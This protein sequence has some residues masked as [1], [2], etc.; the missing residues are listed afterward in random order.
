M[1]T[2]TTASKDTRYYIHSIIALCIMIFGRFVP[3]PYPLTPEGMLVLG[4]LVGAVYSYVNQNFFWGS[5]FGLLIIGTS[6]ITTVGAVF[7]SMMSNGTFMF[8]TALFLFVGYLNSVGFAR[9][10][11]LKFVQA[12]VTKGRPWVLTLFLMIAAFLPASVMSVTAVFVMMLPILYAIC[13]EVG[14]QPTEKWPVL[15]A[16]GIASS[17]GLALG[18]WPF[19]VGPVV[20]FGQMAAT[21]YEGGIPFAQY[22]AFMTVVIGLCLLS[23]VGV[24]KFLK[25]DV[26]KLYAY[27]PP[28]EKVEFTSDQKFSLFLVGLLLAWFILPQFIPAGTPLRIFFAQFGPF[29]IASTIVAFGTFVR[30]DG[31]SRIDM[32]EATKGLQLWPMIIMVGSVLVMADILTRPEHGFVDFVSVNLAP[33]FGT[34]NALFFTIAIMFFALILT[35]FVQGSLVFTIMIPIVVPI[36]MALGFPVMASIAPFAVVANMGIPLPSSHPL[37]AVLHGHEFVG[38]KMTLK[39]IW[40]FMGVFFLIALVIGVPLGMLIF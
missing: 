22:V 1:S 36:A 18:F 40:I 14:I 19:Q 8:L 25:P 29:A 17:C 34:G 23:I 38:P 12:K 32:L 3:A 35:S 33:I 9:I 24:I 5:I 37:G 27:S 10:V 11:A 7:S 39:Y 2:A 31:K 6:E 30:K 21:G 13:E 26:S 15:T 16:I 28:E 20:M 4:V